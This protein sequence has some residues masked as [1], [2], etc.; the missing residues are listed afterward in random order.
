[1][2]GINGDLQ[3]RALPCLDRRAPKRGISNDLQ[4]LTMMVMPL[5]PHA[6]SISIHLPDPYRLF[7]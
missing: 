3:G 1:M 4:R 5:T 2:R 6:N 7:V